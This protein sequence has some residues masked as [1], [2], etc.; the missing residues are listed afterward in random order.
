MATLHLI[1]GLP[2]TGKSTLAARLERE[3][4]ALRLSP[5]DWIMTLFGGDGRD[6]DNRAHVET[7][8]TD[9]ALRALRLGLDVVLD[10]G[11][12]HR[13]ER[14]AY[15]TRAAEVGASV[16]LYYLDVDKDEVKRRL[17]LRNQALPPNT[18]LV[19]AEDIDEWW[20]LIERPTPDEP[21]LVHIRE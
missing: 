19:T 3:H 1:C 20:D 11:F 18:F 10:N 12:W 8:Q 15:R 17:A 16:R 5:D 14:D 6:P 4:K 7:L 2:G 21:G 9:I 13:R